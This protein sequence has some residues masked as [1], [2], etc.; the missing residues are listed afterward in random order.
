MARRP[1][2][3]T[4]PLPKRRSGSDTEASAATKTVRPPSRVNRRC[5]TFWISPEA[6]EMLRE[7]A[8]EQRL[9]EQHLGEEML[10]DLF[11][12]YGKHR[13]AGMKDEG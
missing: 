6:K 10:N 2:L 9:K 8:Y 11:A 5:L 3:S 1:S 4:D 7:I 13:L 12:K